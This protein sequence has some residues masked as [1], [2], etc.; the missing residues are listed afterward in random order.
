MM[1]SNSYTRHKTKLNVLVPDVATL[2]KALIN[3][4]TG[5]KT[6]LNVLVP[7]VATLQKALS[8]NA[9]KKIQK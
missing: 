2:Q 9:T 5:H 1:H 4:Y 7:D 6:K 3:N 8:N